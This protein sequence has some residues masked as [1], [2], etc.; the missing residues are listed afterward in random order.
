VLFC[1][2]PKRF[3]EPYQRYLLS[4]IRD[5]SPFAEVPIKLLLR[6]RERGDARDEIEPQED[7]SPEPQ[8]PAAGRRTRSSVG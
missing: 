5:G 3:S 1:S 7:H 6:R 8:G 2:D 4:A